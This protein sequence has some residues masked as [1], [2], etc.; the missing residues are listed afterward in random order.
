MGLEHLLYPPPTDAFL[1]QERTPVEGSCPRCHGEDIRRY[2][3]MHSG[4]P[5][6][7]TKCQDCFLHLE[8]AKPLPEDR[9]PPFHSATRDWDASWAE[10]NE[11]A[12]SA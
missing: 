12:G 6:I 11:A 7:A 1:Y 10:G 5:L 3:V 9:W 2:P 4:V 8:L